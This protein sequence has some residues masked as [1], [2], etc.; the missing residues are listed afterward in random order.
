MIISLK[1]LSK[2][3]KALILKNK[4]IVYKISLFFLMKII[5][6]ALLCALK[7]G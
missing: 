6:G 5:F 4:I 2:Y 3:V 1:Y 7:T